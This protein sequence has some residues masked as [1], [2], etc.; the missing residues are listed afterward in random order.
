MCRLLETIKINHG[1]L[2]NISLHNERFNR[3]RKE[4]FG[5]DE[6]IELEEIIHL[7]ANTIN[8]VFKCRVVYGR[9]IEEIEI[10]PYQFR[11]INSLKM[12]EN[13]EIE[14]TY[15]YEDRN[16]INNLFSLRDKCDDILIVSKGLLTDTSYCN[17]VFSDGEKLIT[18]SMPLLK[19]TKR[20]Q[21][22]RKGIIAEDE[23]KRKDIHLFKK[24]FLINAMID[25][26]DNLEIL[27]DKIF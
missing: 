1:K 4:L 6:N 24:V 5:V 9:F 14:Y 12:I 25:L 17:I 2:L 15:K 16:S 3:S 23:I 7:Q 18:P 19:G 8:G 27:T 10:T 22:L 21:L 20:E 11:S 13:N 26:E